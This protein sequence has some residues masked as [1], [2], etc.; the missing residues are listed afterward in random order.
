M[1]LE[2]RLSIYRTNLLYLL[3]A[4][5][6]LG[7]GSITQNLNFYFGILVTEILII[8]IPSIYF[9]KRQGGSIKKT[10]RLNRLGFKNIIL[11]FLI[12][13][14]S[15]PIAS[16]FQALFITVL[17]IFIELKPNPLPEIIAQIPFLWSVVFI[18][19]IP[20]ICEEIMFRGPVLRAYEKIGV[21]KAIIISGILFGMFHFT[22]IN[23]IGPAIL[24]IIFGMMVYKTNSI[25]SSMI[26]H[27]LNNS[28]AL[29]LSHFLLE[30][31]DNLP[32]QEMDLNTN[33][34]ETIMSFLV[35][36]LF[37]F[38]LIKLVKVLLKKLSSNAIE[39]LYSKEEI[40]NEQYS[41]GDSYLNR[42]NISFFTFSPILIVLI[43]FF[44]FNFIFILK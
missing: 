40:E 11:I 3:L 36:G 20:G 34:S 12:T 14:L 2:N 1:K 10:F 29:V 39:N 27:S 33:I 24:G 44:I 13:I 16:F 17:D 42:E 9:V 15:Y 19:I 26:A 7:L 31:I 22:L 21:K 5:V 43:M 6:F 23:F 8:A 28:I 25:Y 32:S 37:I 18:A 35:L 38:A 41:I 30:N 4:I